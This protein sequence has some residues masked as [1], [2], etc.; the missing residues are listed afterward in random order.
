LSFSR[1]IL[2]EVFLLAAF[3]Q[4]QTPFEI[5][6]IFN[7]MAISRFS[8]YFL[9]F[10][11][12][13]SVALAH[14]LTFQNMCSEDVYVGLLKN[15][16]VEYLPENGGFKLGRGANRTITVPSQWGGRFWPRTGCV[17]GADGTLKCETGDCGGRLQCGGIGGEV[18]TT[19]AEIT[20][21][22]AGNRDTDFYDVSMVDAYNVPI[23]MMPVEG[24]YTLKGGDYDCG[25]GGTCVS[26]FLKTCP[27]ILKIKNANGTVVACQAPCKFYDINKG[28]VSQ[29]VRDAYCCDGACNDPHKCG[30][31]EAGC[32]WLPEVNYPQASKAACP[33]AYSY[34]YDDL[35]STWTC[36]NRNGGQT[37]YI[38]QFCSADY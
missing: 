33:G 23:K 35:T 28:L 15:G 3:A 29:Q 20:F 13:C 16:N 37:S 25:V 27:E 14:E 26:D 17:A 8:M 31:A 30:K 22:G 36:Q 10:M 19:L 34:P 38:V 1:V 6:V 21:D 7:N 5:L 2:L 12:V 11:T 24:S 18:T 4:A 9:G 32:A